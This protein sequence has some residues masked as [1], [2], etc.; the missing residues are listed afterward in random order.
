[1]RTPELGW[2][3]GVRGAVASVT[4]ALVILADGAFSLELL[5]TIHNFA[6]AAAGPPPCPSP[7]PLH[8]STPAAAGAPSL[9]LMTPVPPS[10]PVSLL[11][12]ILPLTASASLS[13]IH[14]GFNALPPKPQTI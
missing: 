14:N 5:F 6:S 4:V 2:Q 3:L 9:K 1:V 10:P 8:T 13:P 12:L 7:P 11:A